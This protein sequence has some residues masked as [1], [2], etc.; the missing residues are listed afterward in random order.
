MKFQ[1]G[2]GAGLGSSAEST[3]GFETRFGYGSGTRRDALAGSTGA[4][5][6]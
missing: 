4:G 2:I 1:N 6:G 3:I 5:E